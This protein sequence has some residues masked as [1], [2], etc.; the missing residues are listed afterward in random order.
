M[1]SK[2]VLNDFFQTK[3]RYKAVLCAKCRGKGWM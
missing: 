1:G 3:R 2:G